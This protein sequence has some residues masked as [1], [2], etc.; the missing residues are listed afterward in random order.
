MTL[1]IKTAA[2]IAAE[3]LAEH[4]T[5]IIQTVDARIE[6]QARNMGYNSAVSLASHVSSTVPGW[7]AEANAFVAWRDATWL[8]LYALESEVIAGAATAD[9][10]AVLD[11]LPPWTA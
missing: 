9:M 2:D 3:A 4:R 1:I 7:A 6:A 5:R 11:V 8:A 10:A